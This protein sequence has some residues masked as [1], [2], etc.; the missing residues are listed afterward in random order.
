[1]G[2]QQRRL[3]EQATGFHER[4]PWARG[5][6]LDL[7]VSIA[8]ALF[9][10]VTRAFGLDEIAL[11]KRLLYWLLMAVGTSLIGGAIFRAVERYPALTGRR[12]AI[13]AVSA[14]L[15]TLVFT[16]LI[17]GLTG[18]LIEPVALRHLPGFAPVVLLVV[19]AT[20]G[21][22]M[23]IE[24]ATPT[25]AVA[26][27][28]ESGS[29]AP[30]TPLL[31][32]LPVGFRTARILALQAEGHCLRVYTTAG[33]TLIWKSLAQAMAEVGALDGRRVHRA[34]WVARDA[35]VREERAG[36]GALLTLSDG[37]RTPVS[38][39]RLAELRAEG[40]LPGV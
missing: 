18:L 5:L 11:P 7:G 36:R 26:P 3:P 32:S 10:T 37:A 2:R 25:K 23:L 33:R 19:A 16:P 34:W 17:W 9:L 28:D 39:T 29:P 27:E 14:L 31:D 35:V 38:R 21:V 40:W 20:T 6:L 8:M 4:A 30:A 22:R 13:W 1:M 15:M 24:V 12:W